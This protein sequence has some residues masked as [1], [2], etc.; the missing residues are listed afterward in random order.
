MKKIKISANFKD[1]GIYDVIKDVSFRCCSS[2]PETLYFPISPKKA[3]LDL[4]GRIAQLYNYDDDRYIDCSNGLKPIGIFDDMKNKS[5]TFHDKLYVPV[6]IGRFTFITKFFDKNAYYP[7]NC[8]LCVNSY[9]ILT[10]LENSV[11]VAVCLQQ[12]KD[13]IEALWL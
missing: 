6:L 11:A 2:D 4:T 7:V 8:E 3:K 5:H 13:H 10:N 12:Y 1:E 9:G